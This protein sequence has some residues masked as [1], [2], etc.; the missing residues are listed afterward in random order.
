MV[1][2]IDGFRLKFEFFIAYSARVGILANNLVQH[3]IGNALLHD[4]V[5][6]VVSGMGAHSWI[7]IMSQI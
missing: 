7:W 3:G 1:H 5:M 4:T 2:K 6:V